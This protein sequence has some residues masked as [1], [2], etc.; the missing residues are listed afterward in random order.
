MQKTDFFNHFLVF[1]TIQLAT[2]SIFA[3]MTFI[4]LLTR[5][6]IAQLFG[7]VGDYLYFF[8]VVVHNQTLV[9]F[10]CGLAVYRL[11]CVID[12]SV[13]LNMKRYIILKTRLKTYNAW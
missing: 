5:T 6:P 12:S 9:A 4:S 7:P 3:G 10:G 2:T 11:K 8:V 13:C 1:Q